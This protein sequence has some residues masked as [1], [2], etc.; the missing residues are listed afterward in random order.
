MHNS[1]LPEQLY[2]SGSCQDDKASSSLT[3]EEKKTDED[4]DG[5]N[6]VGIKNYWLNISY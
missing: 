2:R 1:S 5:I 3:Q 6:S 4:D